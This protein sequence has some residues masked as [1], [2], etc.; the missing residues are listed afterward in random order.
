VKDMKEG[1]F[2]LSKEKLIKVLQ[3]SVYVFIFFLKRVLYTLKV[4]DK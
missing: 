2:N 1:V 3:R 4:N